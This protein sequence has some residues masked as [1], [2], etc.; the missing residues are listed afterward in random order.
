MSQKYFVRYFQQRKA[1]AKLFSRKIANLKSALGEQMRSMLEAQTQSVLRGVDEKFAE[2]RMAM[3]SKLQAALDI[4]EAADGASSFSSGTEL[5]S[6]LTEDSNL[7]QCT[8]DRES[9]IGQHGISGAG[10]PDGNTTEQ[11]LFLI[12]KEI[13]GAE[14]SDTFGLCSFLPSW[15]KMGASG[16]EDENTA[17]AMESGNGGTETSVC[18]CPFI[19]SVLPKNRDY[20]EFLCTYL[21]AFF[22]LQWASMQKMSGTPS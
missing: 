20:W 16:K 9:S 11:Q 2:L 15:T 4:K 13:G 6:T 19:C 7:K 18:V 3:D 12:A 5:D 10:T 22:S 1:D 21:I 17:A 14:D 8:A